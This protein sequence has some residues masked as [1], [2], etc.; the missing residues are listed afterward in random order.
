VAKLERRE[1]RGLKVK[2]TRENDKVKEHKW[3]R[4]MKGKVRMRKEAMVGMP[5]MVRK[6]NEVSFALVGVVRVRVLMELAERSWQR[7][8]EVAEIREELS[9]ILESV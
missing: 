5:V 8:E 6:W 3:E 1:Q 2:G 7:V 9:P 4:T